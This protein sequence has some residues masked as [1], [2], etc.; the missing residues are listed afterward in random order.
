MNCLYVCGLISG[1]KKMQ[2][3]Y[4]LRC[5]S[6]RKHEILPFSTTR[7]DPEGIV[8]SEISQWERQRPWDFTYM[9]TRKKPINKHM[10]K[11]NRWTNQTKKEHIDRK[12]RET[13]DK[14]GI[15]AKLVKCMVTDGEWNVGGEHPVGCAKLEIKRWM[16]GICDINQYLLLLS[17]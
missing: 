11:E 13:E 1:I 14:R 15:R 9:W 3:I 16:C 8:L 17:C 12:N 7:V 6:A 5:Y 10:E 2:N 4:K